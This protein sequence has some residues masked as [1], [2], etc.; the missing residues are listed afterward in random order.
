MAG[1]PIS[2]KVKVTPG[3]LSAAGGL[4]NLTGLILTQNS[5]AVAEG[6]VSEYTDAASVETAFGSTSNEA[7]MATVYFS[8]YTNSVQTPSRLLFGGYPTTG[9]VMGGVLSKLL[10][11]NGSWNGVT[12][13]FE[14]DLADKQAFATWVSGQNNTI[15]GVLWD[16]DAEATTAGSTTSFGAW[17]AGTTL[18]GVTAVYQDPLAAALALGWMASLPF[19]TAS[20]R[21]NLDMIQNA[22]VTPAVTD[23]TM[24]DTLRANGYSFY[25]AYANKGDS[26]QF[27]DTGAV[28]GPFLWADSYVNQIWMN[29]N[30]TTDLIDLLLNTGQIPYNTEGDALVEASLQ[31]SINS[32][33]SFGAIQTG[34]T[35]TA[36]QKQQ[37][38]NAAGNT[39]AADTV[40][41]QGWYLKPN[42]STAPA[43]YR[44]KRT[45]PPAQFW[46]SDGQSVQSIDLSSVEVQ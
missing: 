19:G 24:A 22:N 25:G 4:N 39:T 33:L 7:K 10:A 13:A 28:S 18:S 3:V 17:L 38:N 32:A 46:Y 37:I 2:Q 45:V 44:V 34:V 27:F 12:A 20:G 29:A 1:I 23:G 41:T 43:S 31:D 8:G 35:L 9:A 5:A 15:F 26:F 6:T 30:F 14:P 11:A 40:Q 16:T 21:R 42:V 36:S